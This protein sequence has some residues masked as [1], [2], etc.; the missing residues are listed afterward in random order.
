MIFAY[1]D[2]GIIRQHPLRGMAGM[3]RRMPQLKP[4]ALTGVLRLG[5][6]FGK[7]GDGAKYSF[8]RYLFCAKQSLANC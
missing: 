5:F 8:I 7:E 6:S 1:C 2:G 4:V 3:K